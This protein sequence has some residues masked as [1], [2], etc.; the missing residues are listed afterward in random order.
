MII[1]RNP[2]DEK[3]TVLINSSEHKATK[4]LRDTETEG[5][6]VIEH[7]DMHLYV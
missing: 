1:S 6:Y 3:I 5:N 7:P 2:T 4:W